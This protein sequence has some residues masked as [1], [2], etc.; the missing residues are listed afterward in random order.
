MTE[1]VLPKEDV[2]IDRERAKRLF[3][4][5]NVQTP[6]LPEQTVAWWLSESLR[7]DNILDTTLT[8]A[9]KGD[10]IAVS[11][12]GLSATRYA[13][14]IK[15]FLDLGEKAYAGVL[16]LKEAKVWHDDEWRF[17]LPLGLPLMNHR[18]VQLLHFPPIAVLTAYADYLKVPTT[19]RWSEM[20]ARNGA[21]DTDAYQAI[22][23]IAPVAMPEKGGDQIDSIPFVYDVTFK[24]YIDALIEFWA[25]DETCPRPMVAFGG[26]VRNYIS[27]HYLDGRDFSVLRYER[28]K[29]DNGVE[30]PTLA[31]NHPSK[32]YLAIVSILRSSRDLA[33]PQ[34][35]K[36][37]VCRGI[38]ITRQDLIAACWQV[39]MAEGN[40]DGEATLNYCKERWGDKK[41]NREICQIVVEQGGW[42][43][44][45][46]G[47][48]LAAD[49]C[50][51]DFDI[52]EGIVTS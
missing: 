15:Q 3:S 4:S 30:I 49:L 25:G 42:P 9:P 14:R 46:R 20:L 41:R 48:A 19:V 35:I 43:P 29:L 13:G 12:V 45:F 26:P 10:D 39:L 17:L 51:V 32:F 2:V 33:D 11:L 47:N 18:T 1:Y 38:E 22:A 16:K 31:A 50:S 44:I 36:T 23:D 21:K 27:N 24:A 40:A 37:A 8:V 5:I 7:R 52:C 6:E 34:K 28:I